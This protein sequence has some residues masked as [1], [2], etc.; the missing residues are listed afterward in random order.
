[1]DVGAVDGAP[2]GRTESDGWKN[3]QHDV[4]N[5]ESILFLYAPRRELH[6]VGDLRHC[7]NCEYAWLAGNKL[8]KITPLSSLCYLRL[9]DVSTNFLESLPDA[10]FFAELFCLQTLF[11][12]ANDIRSV[13]AIAGISGSTSLRVLTVHSTPLAH[14]PGYRPLVL[15]LCPSLLCLDGA[16]ITDKDFLPPSHALL[17]AL[18]LF[19]D[20]NHAMLPPVMMIDE[21]APYEM[22]ALSHLYIM[23]ATYRNYSTARAPL[24]L[25]R[26]VRGHRGRLIFRARRKIII[27][28]VCCVQRWLLRKYIETKV[29][30]YYCAACAQPVERRLVAL[31]QLRNA[32][33]VG[34]MTRHETRVLY[35]FASD[36]LAVQALLKHSAKIFSCFEAPRVELTDVVVFRCAEAQPHTPG[37]P[38]ARGIIG[39]LSHMHR[40]SAE[41]CNL[42]RIKA[43]PA[44]REIVPFS[45]VQRHGYFVTTKDRLMFWEGVHREHEYFTPT[46]E[47]MIRVAFGR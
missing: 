16:V 1:M 47:R 43:Y 21:E 2:I 10:K 12:H 33:T 24:V 27:P 5:F 40:S 35:F 15:S 31:R 19:S 42:L 22:H 25:Q 26:V 14:T 41:T 39:R 17:P 6:S 13:S 44:I 20:L 7:I 3:M 4:Q 38:L 9:L 11:L 32:N 45:V 34:W 8:D 29:L 30:V 28:A 36:V 46:C 23:L 18:S 37:I